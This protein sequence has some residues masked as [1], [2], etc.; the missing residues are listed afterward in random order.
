MSRLSEWR[1]GQTVQ[2]ALPLEK[3]PMPISDVA[4]MLAKVKQ[5]SKKGAEDGTRGDGL[6]PPQARNMGLGERSWRRI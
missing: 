6:V 5:A 4:L 3:E 2:T 1:R